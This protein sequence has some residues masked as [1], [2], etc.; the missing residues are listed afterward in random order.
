MSM[1]FI[2][3]CKVPAQCTALAL[4][5]SAEVASSGTQHLAWKLDCARGKSQLFHT[6]FVFVRSEK[7]LLPNCLDRLQLL[8]HTPR[9]EERKENSKAK[10]LTFVKTF[11]SLLSATS[12]CS[13]TP[14]VSFKRQQDIGPWLYKDTHTFTPSKSV[15]NI[16]A[17]FV[18]LQK[19][20]NKR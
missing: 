13:N 1:A 7:E 9:K 2:W 8:K 19:I 6:T 10:E 18:G 20:E 16:Y 4:H 5:S 3:W 15:Y 11:Y 12:S 17:V 14:F